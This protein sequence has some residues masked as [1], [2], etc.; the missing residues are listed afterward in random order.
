MSLSGIREEKSICTIYDTLL[1]SISN[2]TAVS[3]LTHDMFR[4]EY[5]RRALGE[6]IVR[7]PF[8]RLNVR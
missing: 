6:H 4:W 5:V 3:S 2:I 7:D 1:L 8:G